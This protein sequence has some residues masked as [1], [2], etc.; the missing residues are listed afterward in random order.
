[1]VAAL[2]SFLAGVVL[3]Q[4]FKVI[5]LIPASAV[6]ILGAALAFAFAPTGAWGSLGVGLLAWCLLQMGY[7]VGLAV[8]PVLAGETTSHRQRPIPRRSTTDERTAP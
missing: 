1:M 2:I 8:R 6:V 5:V 4:R 3:G 7:F